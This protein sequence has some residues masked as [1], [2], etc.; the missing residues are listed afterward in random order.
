MAPTTDLVSLLMQLGLRRLAEDLAD[1]IARSTKSRWSPTQLLEEMSRLE[2]E[3]RARRSIERRLGRAHIGR[4]KPMAD[5]DWK[6][7]KKIDR[8]GVER[9]LALGFVEQAENVILV[10]PHGLAT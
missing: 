3:D 6:W 5:F 4:F 10:A 2:I 7:P 1:F 8:E 9:I